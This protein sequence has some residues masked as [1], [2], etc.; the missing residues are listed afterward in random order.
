MSHLVGLATTPF[1]SVLHLYVKIVS[2][3][4]RPSSTTF[5][6]SVGPSE[7]KEHPFHFPLC[8]GFR[9]C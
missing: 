2:R 6:V 3:A 9:V 8:V 7:R 4:L 1:K 5:R